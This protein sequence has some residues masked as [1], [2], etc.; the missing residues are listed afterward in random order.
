LADVVTWI[1]KLYRMYNDPLK[2]ETPHYIDD[3][4]T[5]ISD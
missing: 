4:I 3:S 1:V 5:C 2:K